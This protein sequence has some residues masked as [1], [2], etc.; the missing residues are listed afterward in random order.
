MNAR[1]CVTFT[2]SHKSPAL[3]ESVH[4]DGD[5]QDLLEDTGVKGKDE[6]PATSTLIKVKEDRQS[7]GMVR[8]AARVIDNSDADASPR[9]AAMT[10]P[11]P[12]D[13]DLKTVVRH[14]VN[15]VLTFKPP[16]PSCN[17][18]STPLTEGDKPSAPG[19]SKAR[20]TYR[21]RMLDFAQAQEVKVIPVE[22][23]TVLLEGLRPWRVY[24]YQVE[25]VDES[26]HVIGVSKEDTIDTKP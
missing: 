5:V 22:A 2:A 11:A 13:L 15:A 16:V 1:I 8:S 19:L 20:T 23:G 17:A 3:G 26:G 10:G 7:I 24:R 21:V 4:D 25:A 18:P 12:L 14:T 6:Q 9:A